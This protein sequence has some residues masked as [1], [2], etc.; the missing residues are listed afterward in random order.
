MRLVAAIPGLPLPWRTLFT[1]ALKTGLRDGETT[2]LRGRD[3]EWK[4]EV[5]G[6]RVLV[7]GGRWRKS[8]CCLGWRAGHCCAASL[9][10]GPERRTCSPAGVRAIEKRLAAVCETAGIACVPHDLRHT[11]ATR[12]VNREY[13]RAME[14]SM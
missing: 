5:E 13:R 9:R 10:V 12:L 6:L 14:P 1:L 2:G 11:C 3:L 8:P 7:K 4:P